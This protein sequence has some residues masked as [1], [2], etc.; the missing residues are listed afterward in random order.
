[1]G[2]DETTFTSDVASA[3]SNCSQWHRSMHKFFT[4]KKNSL[5]TGIMKMGTL[6][7]DEVKSCFSPSGQKRLHRLC[8]LTQS[9]QDEQIFQ[10]GTKSDAAQVAIQQY[11]LLTQYPCLQ[12]GLQV[13]QDIIQMS[14]LFVWSLNIQWHTAAVAWLQL[15]LHFRSLKSSLRSYN[16]FY[17]KL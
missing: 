4:H 17:L 15:L 12:V 13:Q 7:S 6:S 2:K 10:W 5:Y 8:G 1:M 14:P 16:F 3:V 11:Y 9:L